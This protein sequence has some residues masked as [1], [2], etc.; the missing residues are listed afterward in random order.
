MSYLDISVGPVLAYPTPLRPFA[1]LRH[2]LAVKRERD[3][4]AALEAHRLADIGV[5]ARAA[6]AEG[7]RP[8]WEL[9]DQRRW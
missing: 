2:A 1:W 4:L 5:S 3:R 8:L 7:N 9:P 6:W